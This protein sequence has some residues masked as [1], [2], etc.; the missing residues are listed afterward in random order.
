MQL[1]R[2]AAVATLFST[3]AWAIPAQAVEIEVAYPYSHLFDVTYERT[4]EEFK[5]AH[6][7]IDVK[8][9]ATYESYEDG[10]NSILRE[11]VAG[12]LPD[13]TMQGLNRQ[14]IL[15]EKG[16]ARS[17]EPFIS[18]EADFEKDGYHKAMLDLG[19]FDGEVYGLPFSISLPVGYY[20]M[21]LMEKGRHQ[22]RS[23]SHN[24]GRGDRG[25]RQ[26]LGCGRRTADALGLEHHWQLVPAGTALVSGRADH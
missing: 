7:D 13:I 18:K 26:T 14:A 10:T 20:N 22:C 21:D 9:R 11:S 15:V 23:A 1:L 6:P 17:L 4:M 24:V 12:T 2:K 19:T 3:V 25:V 16:I 8:F 5:K